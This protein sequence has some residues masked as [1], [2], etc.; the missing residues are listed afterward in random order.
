MQKWKTDKNLYDCKRDKNNNKEMDY[1]DEYVS[2]FLACDPLRNWES[3]SRCVDLWK[4]FINKVDSKELKYV[5]DVG[6]KDGQFTQYLN[7][8]GFDCQGIEI[9]QQYVQFAQEKNRNVVFGDV[10]NLNRPDGSVEVVF[11]HHVLGLCPSFLSA[12]TEMMNV[13]NRYVVTLDSIPG[14]KR[15]HYSYMDSKDELTGILEKI[16]P[17]KVIY[18]DYWNKERP[19]ELVTILEKK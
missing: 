18:C 19:T 17:H 2:N 1:Y 6:T 12:Y 10:T 4:F 8:N 14:N 5:L 16:S 13:T 15:K 7:D 3:V 11:A 9:D